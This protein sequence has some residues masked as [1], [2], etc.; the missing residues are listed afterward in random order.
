MKLWIDMS[1]NTVIIDT[2]TS[3]YAKLHPI[4]IEEVRVDDR[5]WAPRLSILREVT[6]PSQYSLLESTGRI[7]N[8]RRAAGK[9]SAPFSGLH[10]NDS[11]VYKWIEAVAFSLAYSFDEN[12]Y[13]LSQSVIEEIV[14]SQDE[15]GYLN[16]YFTFELK[17]MRWGNLRDSHELYCAGHLIQAGIAYYRSTGRR[18]LL[19]TATKFADNIYD[20]FLARDFRCVDGHPEVEMALVELYRTTRDSRYLDL[21]CFFIDNRGLGLIGGSPYHIDHKPFRE[22][23][24]IVGHAVRA[25]YLNCG[26][27][28]V[29]MEIGDHRI[30]EALRRLWHSMVYRKMYVTGGVGS[31]YEGEAFGDDYELPNYRAY[32]ETCAAIA[33]VMWNWRMLNASG[34]AC[35]TDIMELA[36]YNAT[37]SGIS[38]DGRSY[39]Y[40]NPLADRGGHRRQDWF[41]CACCPPN[42]AR[43]IASIPGYIYSKSI[44]GLWVNLYVQS[45]ASTSLEYGRVTL[46]Q[47]TDYPWSGEVMLLIEP[48]RE[49]EFSIYLRIPGWCRNFTV[50]VNG[51]KLDV[52]V[53][54]PSYV[55]VKR[56]W[57]YGDS[58]KLSMDMPV[59]LIASHPRVIENT[60]RVAM[61]RGPLVYCVEQA[62]NEG[63]DVWDLAID[64]NARFELEWSEKILGGI[65][66]I[67]CDGYTFELDD[68]ER[69][70]YTPI[71]K[72]R[73]KVRRVKFRAIP[74]YAW[75]NRDPGPMS[76]WIRL[77]DRIT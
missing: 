22:L 47:I 12:L 11:D 24:E 27:T 54:P 8:F 44:K 4:P 16:T 55:E 5:F 32:S 49:D 74:Y 3:P 58:I 6:L 69:I 15:D 66:R 25:L 36:L 7:D 46:R 67:L 20:T 71:D 61:M 37:L 38:I 9:I 14:A 40:V 68:S 76:I 53:K 45:T 52:D 48:E 17:D 29:Y 18:D 34:D 1:S 73:Y 33:N 60:G 77:L 62:D 51:R 31:R 10:F 63:F 56:V 28:D 30:W 19:N 75:A 72:L 23:S 41:A 65:M 70:L 35:Y 26:A 42:I 21:A 13:K 2:S 59:E 50:E 64:R 43:L 57:S 39:F